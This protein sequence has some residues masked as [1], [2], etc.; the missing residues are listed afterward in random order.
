[1]KSLLVLVLAGVAGVFA[2][3]HWTAEAEMPPAAVEVAPEQP[4]PVDFAVKVRVR[5]MIEEWKNRSAGGAR[6]PSLTD[7]EA[8]I[9]DIRRRLY[10][11][12]LHDE[13]SL[14]ELMNR[15]AIELGHSP[16]QAKYLIGKVIAEASSAPRPSR[17]A[18]AVASDAPEPPASTLR[19]VGGGY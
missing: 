19:S 7:I 2:Y 6:R 15:A 13:Q 11:K 16:E 18:P 3:R 12:G 4:E 14:K 1:M 17:P 9:N 10:D 5:R 8:E